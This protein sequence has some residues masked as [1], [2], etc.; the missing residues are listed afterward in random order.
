MASLFRYTRAVVCEVP[1]SLPANALRLS[2]DP[3][4]VSLEKALAQHS[5]YVNT[6][7]SLGLQVSVLEA[8]EN[9]PDC[10]F[11]EDVAVVCDKIALITR[12]GHASRRGEAK[13][14]KNVLENLG[15][16][17][18]EME[19]P[20][21]LDGGDVLFTGREFFVGL[22]NRSNNDGVNAVAKVFSNYP[23]TGIAVEQHLHLKS[24]M[25]MLGEDLIVVGASEPAQK[26]WREIQSKA[27]YPY[28]CMVVPED[29]A[30][31]CL[32]INGTVVHL[33][34]DEIPQSVDLFR[35]LSCPRVELTNS[36]LHKVD[37]CLT[38]CS[39]LIE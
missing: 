13:R 7:K 4:G 9:H 1:S 23:V 22:S 21:C 27:K 34:A 31:N 10:V 19:D 29:S 8:D 38:C 14:M 26:A 16:Q 12:L 5:T 37:G 15:L 20:A 17:I 30:A 24:M 28:K 36:E 3:D 6:L 2:S 35:K 25:T 11:V 18:H 32:V 33:N 39:I